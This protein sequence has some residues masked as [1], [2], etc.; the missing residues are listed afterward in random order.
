MIPEVFDRIYR[1]NEWAGE[2]TRSGPGSHLAPTRPVAEALLELVGE[3]GIRTV[4]DVGCGEGWWQPELPGYVG[5]DVS[6]E[7]IRRARELH[8]ER[9]YMLRPPDA[10]IPQA[11]LV[12]TR[13]AMQHLSLPE[14]AR[15]L[16]LIRESGSRYLLASTYV[17]GQ[18]VSIRDGEFYS[19]DL[20]APPFGMPAPLRLIPDGYDY[21]TGEPG[22][23]PAKHL[24]LW[25]LD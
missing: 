19:P 23:D 3:L 21:G 16:A 8:P 2:E 13:D 25:A 6:P 11:D 10:P 22:R 4:L 5:L 14:G 1:A 9:A 12:I 17:G 15:L 18:N 24:G 7:A 20:T